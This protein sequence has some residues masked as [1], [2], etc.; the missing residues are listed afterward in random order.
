MSREARET[1]D[2]SY[3]IIVTKAFIVCVSMSYMSAPESHALLQFKWFE[4][5]P[6]HHHVSN[7]VRSMEF[8]Q[9]TLFLWH[10]PRSILLLFCNSTAYIIP[11]IDIIWAL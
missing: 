6:C 8:D 11:A 3:D 9:P 5:T 7:H 2:Q 4:R 1:R 10:I